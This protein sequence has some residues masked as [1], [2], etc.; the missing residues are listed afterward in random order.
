M[1]IDSQVVTYV[2]EHRVWLLD[3]AAL[4]TMFMGTNRAVLAVVGLAGFAIVIWLRKWRMAVTTG[5]ALVASALV[6]EV[7]KDLIGRGR[8]GPSWALVDAAGSAMP[9]AD[10]AMTAAVGIA[11]FLAVD[12]PTP[13]A[14]RIGGVTL[15]VGEKG[16]VQ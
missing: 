8:P 15:F 4:A 6:S 7:L 5:F 16:K 12:W 11:I 1:E 10:A 3:R 13:L 9:S 14:R 2:A